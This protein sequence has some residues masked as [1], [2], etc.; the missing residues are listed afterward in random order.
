MRAST[1]KVNCRRRCQKQY[2]FQYVLGIERTIHS[3]AP[4]RGSIIHACLE[5]HYSGKDW[6]LPI[7]SLTIDLDNVFD[8][9]REM[10]ANLPD[11]LYRIVRGYLQTYRED[12]T[13]FEVLAT[14]V[15]F[16]MPLPN[17]HEYE[18]I[19]DKVMRE[20]GQNRLWA[21]DYKAVGDIPEVTEL[22]M[23]VQT[24]MYARGIAS[25]VIKLPIHQGEKVGI[26][27]DHIRTKAPRKP[28]ILKNGTV[29]KSAIV[30]DVTTYM[31]TVKAQGLDPKDY[32][33]MLPKLQKHVFFRRASI[34]A[35]KSTIQM[36]EREIVATLDDTERTLSLITG[37]PDDYES[38]IAKD[39]Y[40]FPR[41]YL[42]KRCSWDC[43]YYKLCVGEL[44][45]MNPLNII[46]AEYQKR[47]GRP[48]DGIN[49]EEA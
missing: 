1:T 13:R 38:L 7:T 17:G 40:L 25:G 46:A 15:S 6:T 12:D 26:M 20:I 29:S 27:F 18:G 47:K 35:R 23:D 48:N 33:D 21:T 8:E 5:N 4:S 44:S 11:E 2:F 31:D 30:T 22:F 41:T 45:G 43:Q 37:D 36:I 19:I 9:E 42:S 49:D 10:W 34:P 24:C 3:L 32:S 28:D 14:E 39:S 16:V